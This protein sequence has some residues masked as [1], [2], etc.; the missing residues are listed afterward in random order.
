[1][2]KRSQFFQSLL[3]IPLFRQFW[4][5]WK[6]LTA[7]WRVYLE[8]PVPEAEIAHA[9]EAASIPSFGFF[10]L[11]ICASILATLGLLAN[12][13]PVIIGAMIIAP[14]M[15]PILSMA[16]AIVTANWKLYKRSIITI[17]L[18]VLSVILISYGISFLLPINVV[19]SEVVARISPNLIDLGIAIAAG[20]AG[21]F[22]LTR[23]SIASSIAGVAIAVA[24]VPPLC[25]VG[26]GLGIGGELAVTIGRLSITNFN[27][28]TGAFLLFLANLAGI[29]FTACLVFLS[30][31][32][33][34][35]KKSFQAV[36]IW[37][38]IMGILCGPLT[39]SLQEFFV[40]NR[41]GFEMNRMRLDHPQIWKNTQIH[42]L[43]VELKGSTAYVNILVS[44]PQGV[45]TD[46]DLEVTQKRLFRTIS[47][48]G[49][50]AMDLNIRIVP[51][52]LREYQGIVEN[53]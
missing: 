11:L 22:S 41:L 38:L 51:V 35:F 30:Q 21:S 12:S 4:V 40:S 8:I 3:Q 27:V 24:L 48:A 6:A 10:L 46:E 50:N 47:G 2:K 15:N 20:A 7:S 52:K 43:N 32:Y 17:F 23:Q 36:I 49:V 16:F 25:V 28:S 44:A 13:I 19:G 45:I 18:G 39:N 1:M 42:H 9:R 29:T 33:G 14:L 34:S 37:L 31:S 26:I 53:N 5:F